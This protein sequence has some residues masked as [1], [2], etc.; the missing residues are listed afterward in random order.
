MQNSGKELFLRKWLKNQG[1]S[2]MCHLY[3]LGVGILYSQPCCLGHSSQTQNICL[4]SFW[5]MSRTSFLFS[6][7]YYFFVY[8]FPFFALLPLNSHVFAL[9]KSLNSQCGRFGS[10]SWTSTSCTFDFPWRSNFSVSFSA[11]LL[12]I[13]FFLP[14]LRQDPYICSQI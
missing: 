10:V 7:I 9:L 1:N 5:P 12:Q 2:W 13:S 8:P 6:S 14:P 3:K 4:F 11:F